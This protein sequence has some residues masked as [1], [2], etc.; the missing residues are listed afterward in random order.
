MAVLDAVNGCEIGDSEPARERCRTSLSLAST[1]GEGSPLRL[2]GIALSKR[3]GLWSGGLLLLPGRTGCCCEREHPLRKRLSML[4]CG[5]GAS[6]RSLTT[7][8][9]RGPQAGT[10]RPEHGASTPPP[11]STPP[12]CAR[13][14]RG[15]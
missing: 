9:S 2:E 15:G 6:W 13:P 8:S 10:S 4:P 1:S 14:G 5:P 11:P 3:A 7:G 12:A